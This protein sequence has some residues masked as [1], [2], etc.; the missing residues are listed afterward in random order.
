MHALENVCREVESAGLVVTAVILDQEPTHQKI[1]R[2]LNGEVRNVPFLFDVPHLIKSL[3]N[4]L[5][6]YK[7]QVK[8]KYLIHCSNLSNLTFVFYLTVFFMKYSYYKKKHP[9]L[10]F[11]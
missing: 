7:I 5:L 8:K 3:R 6:K 9:N 2:K 10:K 11:Q 1:V 4:S